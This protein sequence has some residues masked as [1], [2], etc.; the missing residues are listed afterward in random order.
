MRTWRWRALIVLR[1]SKGGA[2]ESE[3]LVSDI[4]ALVQRLDDLSRE[5]EPIVRIAY[6]VDVVGERGT[7]MVGMGQEG[8]MLS[9]APKDDGEVQNSLG[10]AT[11]DGQAAFF[12]GDHTLVSRKYLIARD[13]ALNA[14]EHWCSTGRLNAGVR[15]TSALF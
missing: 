6:A 8:W 3:E 14:L 4:Q 12:F 13:D 2:G 7:M 1:H 10:D 5:Y 11:A 9:F 15:W